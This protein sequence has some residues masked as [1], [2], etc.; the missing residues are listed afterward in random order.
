MPGQPVC[1]EGE[2]EMAKKK[3][4]RADLEQ[5]LDALK[6]RIRE[7]ATQPSEPAAPAETP[8]GV[9]AV[10]GLEID[11]PTDFDGLMDALKREVEGLNPLT[12]LSIFALGVLT[13]RLLAP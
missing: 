5:E 12:C 9:E 3:R 4:N 8:R 6:E 2:V 13:G 10:A 11:L 1:P 7:L